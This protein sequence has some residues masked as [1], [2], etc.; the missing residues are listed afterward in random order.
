MAFCFIK[1][2]ILLYTLSCVLV[3]MGVKKMEEKKVKDENTKKDDGFIEINL[4][5]V[6]VNTIEEG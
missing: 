5:D 2:G 4:W 1:L 3:I 6:F